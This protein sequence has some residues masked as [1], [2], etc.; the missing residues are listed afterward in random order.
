MD[1]LDHVRAGLDGSCAVCDGPVPAGATRILAQR[2]GVAVLQVACPA[3]GSQSLEFRAPGR[4]E[5]SHELVTADDVLDMHVF[6]A[7]WRGSLAELL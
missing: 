3:C 4:R 7:S 2:D 6:L 1:P 5:P